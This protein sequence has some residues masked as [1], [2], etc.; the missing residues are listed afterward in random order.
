MSTSPGELCSQAERWATTGLAPKPKPRVYKTHY[1]YPSASTKPPPTPGVQGREGDMPPTRQAPGVWKPG[2]VSCLAR[3][4]HAHR[5]LTMTA[6]Q[7]C[8]IAPVPSSKGL[9]HV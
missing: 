4:T 7:P 8:P 9:C 6:G 1:V 3:P 2:D 5:P